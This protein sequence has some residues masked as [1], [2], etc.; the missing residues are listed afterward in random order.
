MDASQGPEA[1]LRARI[2]HKGPIT[3]A[4][5]HEVALYW[6][7]GGYYA[8]RG[9]QGVRSDFYTAPLTHPVFGAL[10]G[11]QLAQMWRLVGAPSHFWTVE[12]GA[13]SGRLGADLEEHARSIDPAFSR[14]LRYVGIDLLSPDGPLPA[15]LQWLRSS[16]L[17]A[18]RLE[19]CV[20]ANELLDAMPVHRVLKQ[21][22]RLWEVLVTLDSHDRFVEVVGE[23]S[24]PALA[25]RFEALGVELPD[26]FR[27]EVNL[28]LAKWLQETF[29]ALSRGYVLLMDYGHEAATLYDASRSRGTLRCYYRH[30]L[31]ANPYQHVGD[32]D[33][34]VHVDFTSVRRAAE[35]LGF[36]VA[37]YATQQEFLTNLGWPIYRADIVRRDGLTPQ[38]RRANLRAM[39]ALV[40]PEGMGGFKVMA[41]S[42]GAPLSPLQ[43]SMPADSLDGVRA[44]LAT[45][46]HMHLWRSAAES[47]EGVGLPSWEELAR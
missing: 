2:R 17:P 12:P 45:R 20:V 33:I 31:N 42:K 10:L 35:A 6:P 26:G 1:E 19:G 43:G 38:E 22:G 37:G 11:R 32:Q 21:A 30:T 18:R 36:T 40:N 16:G 29:E 23:P 28:G 3:F 41:L 7:F 13:G 27:T 39:D 34:S 8:S 24:T 44:P 9:P 14:A 5:F 25:Q 4:E 46:A 15:A 47:G